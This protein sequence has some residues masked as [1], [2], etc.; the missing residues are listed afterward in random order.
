MWLGIDLG[1]SGVKAVLMDDD[2]VICHQADAPLS[3]NRPCPLW[4]EQDPAA[5]WEAVGQA[6]AAL[7]AAGRRAVRAIGL[8]GQMHGACVLGNDDAPLR[9]AILW[10]D[11]RSEAQCLELEEAIPTLG[12][13]TGNRAMAG[14][15]APKLMWLREREPEV[16]KAIAKVLLPKDYIRLK[17][18]GDYASDMSDSAGTLWLDVARR[19]WSDEVLQA[20]GLTR[21]AMPRLYEGNQQTGL[22]RAAVAT[23]LGLPQVPVCGGAGD[24]AA[25]AI[26]VGVVRPGEGML[27]LGTSGVIFVVSDGFAPAPAAALHAFCHALPGTWHQMA[28]TLSATSALDWA[29][30][31]GGYGDVASALAAAGTVGDNEPLP[32]MLP[33]LSGERTPHNNAHASGVLF[34]L[35]HNHGPEHLIRAAMEGVAFALA[36]G[37]A[38]LRL[39]GT[40][41]E[42]LTV[43]GGGAASAVWGRLIAS[44]L[45]CRLDYCDAAQAGAA[46]GAALLARMAVTQ[47]AAA[48]ICTA[49]KV[50]HSVACDV[51]LA[52]HLA[53]RRA[54]Y[55]DLYPDLARHFT[56]QPSRSGRTTTETPK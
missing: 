38:A 29:V 55:S 10:N 44:A 8:A 13:I 45:G 6:I 17:L 54:R 51:E 46:R 14:F 22:L 32:I 37:A 16:F 21:N 56:P 52:G 39:S 47:E 15:T 24:N 19:D 7:P 25:G 12:T 33:Y 40:P 31:M 53:P 23:E 42:A 30:R 49:P 50:S 28:V 5:W 26:G 48:D 43:I 20:C 34:G 9:D 3:I 4:S 27:S 41:I 2:G 36:D 35:G 11:G 18:T 1:T